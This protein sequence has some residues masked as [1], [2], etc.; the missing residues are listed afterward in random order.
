[1]IFTALDVGL[2][3]KLEEW[4]PVIV[5]LLYYTLQT[6]RGRLTLGEAYSNL[7]P[8]DLE[9]R[10]YFLHNKIKRILWV[11]T[12][13][14]VPFTLKR[15]IKS[16]MSKRILET[17]EPLNSILFYYSGKYPSIINR[18]LSIRYVRRLFCKIFFQFHRYFIRGNRQCWMKTP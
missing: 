6:G 9:S 13:V 1:M 10:N 11:I 17:L 16:E 4:L 7:V 14:L 2:Y 18:F 8:V 12:A 3:L 15:R 5:D